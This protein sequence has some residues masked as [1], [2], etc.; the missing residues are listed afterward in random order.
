[1]NPSQLEK[2]RTFHRLHVTEGCFLMPNAW[3]IGSAKM[4]ATAGFPAIATTSAG[5]AFSR[6]RPDH[7]FSPATACVERG[8]MMRCVRD[9]ASSIAVPVNADLEAGYGEA[10][11]DVAETLRLAIE[12]GA[13]GG[14][15]ED[16]T[17]DRGRPLYEEGLAVERIAAARA[18]ITRSGIPFV[19]VARTDAFLV[20][21]A[22]PFAESVR[23]A[24]LYRRAGADC[25]FVPG[26]SDAETVGRLVR[27]IDGPLNIVMGLTGAS[28]A[29]SELHE[30]GVRR[31]SIGAS[32]A[33]A[34]YFQIR[35]AA[36]EMAEHGTFRFASQ[37]IPQEELNRILLSQ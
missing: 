29:L 13:V 16:Y 37:Q 14:N 11:E 32:L 17:G 10:P 24:N 35:S 34:V 21:H 2:A 27:A 8:E 12:A 19:L 6:G 15:I 25:L 3:D 28:L 36:R 23:R 4:L 7:C 33:R 22:D 26:V 5:I 9:I 1:M 31:V 18:A 30:L 20:G